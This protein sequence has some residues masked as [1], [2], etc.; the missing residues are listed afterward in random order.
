M[1]I[2]LHQIQPVVSTYLVVVLRFEAPTQT[3]QWWGL[4]GFLDPTYFTNFWPPA[5]KHAWSQFPAEQLL[6]VDVSSRTPL[7]WGPDQNVGGSYPLTRSST[8]VLDG[9]P[10]FETLT[11]RLA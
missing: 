6:T 7:G 2:R 3:V 9:Y 11:F 1:H 5:P 4:P 8:F 10:K